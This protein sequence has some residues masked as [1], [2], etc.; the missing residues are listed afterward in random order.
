MPWHVSAFASAYR[1]SHVAPTP[2]ATLHRAARIGRDARLRYVYTGNIPHDPWE[3][4]ARPSCGRWLLR[5]RSFEVLDSALE[6]GRC[7]VCRLTIAGVW[8]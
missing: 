5:R 3:D 4:T 1:M 7:P 6:D 8:T 2:V